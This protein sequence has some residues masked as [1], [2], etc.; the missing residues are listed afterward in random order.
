MT[1][2]ATETYTYGEV[3]ELGGALL[4]VGGLHHAIMHI[5]DVT[6][7]ESALEL[8]EFVNH[9]PAGMAATILSTTSLAVAE[10][11]T[12]LEQID[13]ATDAALESLA[14]RVLAEQTSIKDEFDKLIGDAFSDEAKKNGLT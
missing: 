4:Y 1:T 3:D 14:S 9:S 13:Q 6:R 2:E 10:A 7:D 12:R 8:F 11:M 5:L